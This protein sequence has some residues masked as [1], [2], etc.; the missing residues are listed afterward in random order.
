MERTV[1]QVPL[2]GEKP[3]V[4]Q[5]AGEWRWQAKRYWPSCFLGLNPEPP[6]AYGDRRLEDE[7]LGGGCLGIARP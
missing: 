4:G 3:P 5:R 6:G 7:E 2:F 1:P